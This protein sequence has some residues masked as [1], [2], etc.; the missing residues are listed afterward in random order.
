MFKTLLKK[1]AYEL[2][3]LLF[4]GGTR[5]K[6]KKKKQIN[7]KGNQKARIFLFALLFLSIM[8]GVGMLAF[9][10]AQT[11]V[12]LGFQN[13]YFII[14]G[15]T[16]LLAC[17]LFN[18]FI[19][20]NMIFRAKDNDFLLSLPISSTTIIFSR[21]S[22]LFLNCVIVNFFVWIPACVV[23]QFVKF[24]IVSLLMQLLL[25]LAI[26]MVAMGVACFIAWI[27]ALISRNKVT[28]IVLS[29]VGTVVLVVCVVWIR[30]FINNLIKQ[31]IENITLVD[32]FISSN[33]PWLNVL[34]NASNGSFVDFAIIFFVSL[35]FFA[36]VIFVLNK[37]FVL[38]ITGKSHSKHKVYR[39]VNEKS[40]S[41]NKSLLN[42]EIQFFFKTPVYLM[43]A[44][45]NAFLLLL[46]FFASFALFSFRGQIFDVIYQIAAET[47][48]LI[49]QD[50]IGDFL[51][52]SILFST[53]FLCS[54]GTITSP[55][56]SVEGKTIW[57]LKSLPIKVNDIF[58]A[59]I[60]LQLLF[61]FVPAVALVALL[62]CIFY[63]NPLTVMFMVLCVFFYNC[64]TAIFGLYV[65]LKRANLIWTNVVVPIKQNLAVLFSMLFNF[66]IV[67]LF[68]GLFALSIY[69][70][71]TETKIFIL[72]F[73]A[74]CAGISFI[75]WSVLKN[76][77]N[78][79]FQDL[80]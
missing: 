13:I 30:I 28:K 67:I 14:F 65:G 26:S 45:L 2:F 66:A 53:M 69:V 21:I 47:N 4:L 39:V 33:A 55:S 22:V 52:V 42:K 56:V 19:S 20:Y 74:L 40:N 12:P 72:I 10:F 80:D 46:V 1:Q 11:I 49:S 32:S 17:T 54:M 64:A 41:V 58:I 59:K 79:I 31:M 48:G 37:T 50:L 29:V 43:N 76:K 51:A 62:G 23:F 35:V 63:I 68:A 71:F 61:N 25:G 3:Y 27:I 6:S 8:Y 15:I 70:G 38:I 57:I 75:F 73:T 16:S 5:N 60:K 78:Q 36:G 18:V 7:Q 9:M 24:N 34:G 44:G 77:G